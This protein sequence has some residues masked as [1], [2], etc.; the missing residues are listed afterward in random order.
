MQQTLEISDFLLITHPQ[1][2]KVVH[3]RMGPLH[4][5]TPR[6]TLGVETFGFRRSL[7][8]HMGNIAS[9]PHLFLGGFAGIPFIHAQILRVPRR[10]FGSLDHNGVQRQAQQFHV[11]PI[12]PGDDKGER[13]ATPVHQQ[14]AFGSFFSPDLSGY[15]PPLLGPEALCPASRPGFA[16]PK[17][18]PPSR[19]IRPGPRATSAQRT[20]GYANA[21]SA[22]GSRW[23]CQ[24]SWAAPSTGSRC[25]AHTQWRRRCG[26]AKWLSAR[27]PLAADTC[28]VALLADCAAAATARRV[29]KAR[30]T[31]P[32]TGLLPCSNGIQRRFH[33]QILFKDKLLIR[34]E[35]SRPAT[36]RQ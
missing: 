28:A 19:R 18:S 22:G 11:V 17:R 32:K 3:P 16:I 33:G 9:V 31:L 14:T 35:P 2:A 20:P 36:T 15:S 12:G 29:T 24:S 5:P 13:G 6:L 21:E 10:G 25:A 30:R 26:A 1:F 8:R 7:R 34:P 23:H 4:H 27:R